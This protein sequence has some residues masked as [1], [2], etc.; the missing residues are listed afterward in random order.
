MSFWRSI[1][2]KYK[3]RWCKDTGV[4]SDS[5]TIAVCSHCRDIS[6]EIHDARERIRQCNCVPFGLVSK[7]GGAICCAK[8]GIR[9]GTAAI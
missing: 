7:E 5:R 8:C 2:P 1:F 3:C 9:W 6:A 4:A